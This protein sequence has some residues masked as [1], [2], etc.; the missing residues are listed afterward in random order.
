[1]PRSCSVDGCDRPH[2]AR[3]WCRKHYDRWCHGRPVEAD[4]P[5]EAERFWDKVDLRTGVGCW[6]WT[7]FIDDCG[8]GSF[9]APRGTQ[10]A[11]RWSWEHLIGRIPAGM[12]LDHLCRVREC[13][14]PAH[15]EP[16]EVSE[17]FFRSDAPASMNAVKTHCV[18]GHELSGENLYLRPDGGRNCRACYRMYGRGPVMCA[19][20]ETAQSKRGTGLCARCYQRRCRPVERV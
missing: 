1:M 5:S 20:C 12:V 14:N 8:Y 17:N 7:A 2:E 16:V 13:V 6:I 10:A 11:H 19:E 15:L 18:R 4:P 3:G 9:W